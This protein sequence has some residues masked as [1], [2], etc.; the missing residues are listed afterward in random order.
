MLTL[1]ERRCL[2]GLIQFGRGEFQCLNLYWI[3]QSR[4]SAMRFDVAHG[5]KINARSAVEFDQ[6]IGL[7]PRI[8]GSK[9]SCVTP[10]VYRGTTNY[11]IDGIT[12]NDSSTQ[13]L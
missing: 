4:S 9:R 3:T 1:R 12:I 11:R 10:V 5:A 2:A 7:C 13:L 6:E 8:G